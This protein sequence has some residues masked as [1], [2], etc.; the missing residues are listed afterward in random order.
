[1]Y[2]YFPRSNT[3]WAYDESL[4][5]QAIAYVELDELQSISAAELNTQFAETCCGLQGIPGLRYEVISTDQGRCLCKVTGDISELLEEGAVQTC[6][7]EIS[8]NEIVISFAKLLGWTEA[9]TAHAA[10]NLLAEVGDECV[11]MLNNGRCLRM[12]ASPGAVEYVRLTQLQFELGRW[13]ASDFRKSGPELLFQ[14]LTDAGASLLK[15]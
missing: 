13:Y 7:F 4:Q 12:P 6:S 14:V 1:M 10:D 3:Y 8:R 2:A 9:Q 11:V 15:A 5:L